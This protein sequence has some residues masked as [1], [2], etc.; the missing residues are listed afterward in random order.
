M[1]L[2]EEVPS[3][4][5]SVGKIRMTQKARGAMKVQFNLTKE[6]AEAFTNFYNSVNVNNISESDFCKS[7]FVIGL[8]SMEAS[9]I[10][11]VQKRMEAEGVTA[12]G[13]EMDVDEDTNDADE[14]AE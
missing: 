7:A 3:P 12:S 13:V 1:N 5:K 6:E 4:P 8:Q 14:A 10:A 11:E 2:P 9:I